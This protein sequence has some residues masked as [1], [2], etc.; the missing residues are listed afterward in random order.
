VGFPFQIR[1]LEDDAVDAFYVDKANHGPGAD[2]GKVA[3]DHVGGAQFAPEVPGGSKER[4]PLKATLPL[5]LLHAIKVTSPR[6]A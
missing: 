1:S 6:F 2:F 5:S 4:Q 3:L